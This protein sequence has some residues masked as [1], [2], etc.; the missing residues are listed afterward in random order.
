MPDC[1]VAE[2]ECR[3]QAQRKL[4]AA[5]RDRTARM[6]YADPAENLPINGERRTQLSALITSLRGIPGL[7]ARNAPTR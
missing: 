2:H 5:P 7:T 3:S 6:N 4:Q 1:D